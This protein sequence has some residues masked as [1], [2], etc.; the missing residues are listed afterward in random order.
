MLRAPAAG[1]VLCLEL[2]S[3][4]A[5]SAVEMCAASGMRGDGNPVAMRVVLVC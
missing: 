3:R 1:S 5:G 2:L 4:N